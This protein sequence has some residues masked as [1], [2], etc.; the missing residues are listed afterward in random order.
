MNRTTIFNNK[1]NNKANISAASIRENGGLKTRQS[2]IE[3]LR[4]LAAMGV[5]V[6]HY[7]NRGIGGGFLYARLGSGN[8]L[9]LNTLES[10]FIASV[11][12]FVLIN[13]YFSINTNKRDLLKPFKLVIQVMI[14]NLSWYL[15]AVF[16]RTQ[17]LSIRQLIESIIP[18]N[19][20]VIIYCALYLISPFLNV[21]LKRI[22]KTELKVL[23]FLLMVLFS[24]Y[25]TAV[26]ILEGL[27]G[28][29]FNGLSTVGMYG[30]QYGY[31]IV[32]F[33]LV[34]VI[35]AYIKL[36]GIRERRFKLALV[37]IVNTVL[38]TVWS[39]ADTVLDTNYTNAWE[40][41]NPLVILQAV[42]IFLIIRDLDFS[43]RIINSL[44][45]ASFCVYLIHGY[46]ISHIGIKS[47]ISYNNPLI[48]L[49]HI[50]VCCVGIY[51]IGY[52]VNLIYCFIIKYVDREIDKV[53]IRYRRYSIGG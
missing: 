50:I 28:H 38:L 36:C 17:N 35:G 4:I 14:F 1:T 33:V 24:F 40:Y 10:V 25:P 48:T 9:L 51:I 22:S 46:F 41:C 30:S 31:T 23:L 18:S 44:A 7:N 16:F 43:S 42:V 5:I 39:F 11:N 12:I 2:G 49:A 8:S 3:L 15:I 52:V 21:V 26:D 34:Y 47:V 45:K 6:L 32:N 19:W 13:G 29:A 53:W 37:F 27:T 20:F